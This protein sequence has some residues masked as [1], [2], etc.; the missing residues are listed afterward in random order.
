MTKGERCMLVVQV[1]ENA[2]GRCDATG[3]EKGKL[4]LDSKR[5][6]GRRSYAGGG[7]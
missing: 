6:E 1:M 5:S 2:D 7:V 3:Q 4:R